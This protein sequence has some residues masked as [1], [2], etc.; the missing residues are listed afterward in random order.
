[1]PLHEPADARILI[2]DDQELNIRVLE[3]MLRH[4]GY[5]NL[6]STTDSRDVLALYDK[7]QPD[8]LLLDLR[9]PHLDG[10]QIL[11]QFQ[12]HLLPE[13]YV[14]IVI[15]TADV[16][17]EARQRA[18]TLGAKDFVIKPFDR[19]EVLLRIRNLLD[20]RFLHRTLQAQNQHLERLVR[21]R[22]QE[23]ESAQLEILERLAQA[24]EYRD[25]D[26][27]Q[28][29]QRVG[30]VAAR[31][32]EV[33]GLP[34]GEVDLV[35][36]AAPLHDVGKIGISDTILLKPGKLTP[37]EFATMQNHTTIGARILARSRHPLL[38]KAE[39]IAR[40]HHERWDGSGYPQ[41]LSGEAIPLAGRITAVVDVFDALTHVR[42]YKSAWT[43]E[44]AIAEIVRQRGRQF[45]SRVVDAFMHMI[46]NGDIPLPFD[47][48]AT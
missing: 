14:P 46:E 13:T 28:H 36:Q 10:F 37:E 9:M 11:E 34:T 2:V 6:T 42:P 18:L 5:T 33:L 21:V 8:L 26:T 20:T 29:T 44:E 22:T 25:D 17:L 39:E 30:Q 16:T 27:G 12:P 7:L 35:R 15:L 19:T 24:A 23:V 31:L 43:V 4:A 48:A 1:M 32:A 40:T 38:Q 41:R 45:D 3:G 47:A